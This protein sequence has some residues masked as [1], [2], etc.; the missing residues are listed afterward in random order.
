MYARMHTVLQR[1]TSGPC[2]CIY[3]SK[4]HLKTISNMK[5]DTEVQVLCPHTWCI[6]A[7]DNRAAGMGPYLLNHFLLKVELTWSLCTG[8]TY[9][10]EQEC[11]FAILIQSMRH[12]ESVVAWEV[13]KITHYQSSMQEQ[14]TEEWKIFESKVQVL[15][16]KY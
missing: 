8:E 4:E 5:L 6:T 12:G 10:V 7:A 9:S 13:K 2:I 3:R 1:R 14:F 11:S 16:K 15:D